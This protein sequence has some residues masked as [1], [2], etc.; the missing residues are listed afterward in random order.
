MTV[1][2]IAVNGA[3]DRRMKPVMLNEAKPSRPDQT[4]PDQNM[5]TKTDILALRPIVEPFGIETHAET[6]LQTLK[7]NAKTK[8]VVSK[9]ELSMG[10]FCV[11][12]SNPTHQLTDPTRPN[13]IQ[14]TTPWCN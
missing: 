13:P 14:L 3:L 12:R 4:R 11:I 1:A 6:R 8:I 9:A 2:I 10:P 7:T 5:E